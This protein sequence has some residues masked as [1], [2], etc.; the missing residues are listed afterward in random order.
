MQH[1]QLG[2]A[3]D[4]GGIGSQART[5]RKLRLKQNERK[6]HLQPPPHLPHSFH[7]P[8]SH[9]SLP[10][11]RIPTP[12]FMLSF[13]PLTAFFCI[14]RRRRSST[15]IHVRPPPPF[16]S[17]ILVLVSLFTYSAHLYPS[18]SLPRLKPLCWAAKPHSE[19]KKRRKKFC[20]S[21][22][23]SSRAAEDRP[24]SKAE[25]EQGR[26]VQWKM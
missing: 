19:C 3:P 2:P 22:G 5:S 26:L 18:I 13:A 7:R 17:F 10:V 9:H 14:T 24:V 1:D 16:A 25:K 8:L 11:C 15:L 4:I 12:H 20:V 6:Y 21:N 23:R